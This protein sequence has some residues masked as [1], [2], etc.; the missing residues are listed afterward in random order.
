MLKKTTFMSLGRDENGYLS[1]IKREGFYDGDFYYYSFKPQNK[2]YLIWFAIDPMT[3]LS[4][5]KDRGKKKVIEYV[6]SPEFKKKF[7]NYKI[8]DRYKDSVNI[9]YKKQVEC[10]AIMEL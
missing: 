8:T 10:G 4:V 6:H 3:G 1:A 2:G 7:E 9:W 5:H